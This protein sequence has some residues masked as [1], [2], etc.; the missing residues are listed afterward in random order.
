VKRAV[1]KKEIV[2]E[3]PIDEP[4]PEPEN[5]EDPVVDGAMDVEPD[6]EDEEVGEEEYITDE[7]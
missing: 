7:D 3:V 5:D 6:P 4:E 1:K 2:E